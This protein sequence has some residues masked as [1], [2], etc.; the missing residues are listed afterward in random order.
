MKSTLIISGIDGELKGKEWKFT[1]NDQIFIGRDPKSAILVPEHERKVSRKNSW[2]E[3]RLPNVYIS[4]YQSLNG[5]YVNGTLIGRAKMSDR[6]PGRLQPGEMVEL[7]DQDIIGVGDHGKT[8]IFRISIIQEEEPEDD[9][10]EPVTRVIVPDAPEEEEDEAVADEAAEEEIRKSPEETESFPFSVNGYQEAM[11]LLKKMMQEDM[12]DPFVPVDGAMP[13]Q[14]NKSPDRI[15]D[16]VPAEDKKEKKEKKDKA[17]GEKIDFTLDWIKRKAFGEGGFGTVALYHCDTLNMDCVVKTLHQKCLVSKKMKARFQRE[18]ML[19]TQLIH[20]NIVRTY[21]FESIPAENTYRIL[22][23][24]CKGGNV[25]DLV[26]KNG[27]RLELKKATA[28]ILDVLDALDYVH[29]VEVETVVKGKEKIRTRGVVHRDIKPGN[30]LLTDHSERAQIKL[31]D[32]GLAKAF[33]ASGLAK[34]SDT[35]D[36]LGS[37]FYVPR[38]QLMHFCYAKPDVDVFSTA[39]TYYYLLTGTHIRDFVENGKPKLY[40]VM[41]NDCVPI[42]ERNPM[43][44]MPLARVIDRVLAEDEETD[45]TKV[46]TARQFSDR[47]KEA[48]NMN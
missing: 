22:M 9:W 19:G 17:V 35:T 14:E 29:N 34:L 12:S 36:H 5:T 28:I 40:Q 45:E 13:G 15:E 1:E 31:C 21:D 48:L 24:Y 11:E 27:G 38:K 25:G 32:F 41:D 16:R 4:D 44:P 43:I 42:R 10:E 46:T 8:E 7:S 30:I 39:A 26:K 33:D 2:M 6:E 23:E 3:I 18:A 20:K 37:P 47:I